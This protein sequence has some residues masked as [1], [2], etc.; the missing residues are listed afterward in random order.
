[1]S[2]LGSFLE[3]YIKRGESN[4]LLFDPNCVVVF[5]EIKKLKLE[6]KLQRKSLLFLKKCTRRPRIYPIIKYHLV[7]PIK[8]K[9]RFRRLRNFIECSLQKRTRLAQKPSRKKRCSIKAKLP[10]I[11]RTRSG[12]SGVFSIIFH[13]SLSTDCNG[14][15]V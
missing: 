3:P 13:T 10:W 1:M 8:L 9:N 6:G 2:S 11:F 4:K 15:E 7:K 14:K 12:M 5:N